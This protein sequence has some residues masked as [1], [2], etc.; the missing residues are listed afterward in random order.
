MWV[1]AEPL[2]RKGKGIARSY[3]RGIK[4]GF[5]RILC[6][7]AKY[8]FLITKSV[9]AQMLITDKNYKFTVNKRQHN[10]LTLRLENV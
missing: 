8:M 2:I 7:Y 9:K 1:E 10:F 6:L 4:L 3:V 5:W